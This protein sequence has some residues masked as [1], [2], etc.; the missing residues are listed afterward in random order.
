M[1]SVHRTTYDPGPLSAAIA[2]EVA[3]DG[4]RAVI[5]FV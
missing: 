1:P 3:K 5:P 2:I 4:P